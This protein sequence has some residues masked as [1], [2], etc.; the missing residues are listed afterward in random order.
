MPSAPL[1]ARRV[2]RRALQLHMACRR[3]CRLPGRARRLGRARPN[4]S[5]CILTAGSISATPK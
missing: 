1:V 5:V 2:K 4:A 3:E